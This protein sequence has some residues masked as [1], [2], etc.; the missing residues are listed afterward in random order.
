MK[1]IGYNIDYKILDAK[2][3][4]FHNQE[5]SNY[6]RMENELN[7]KYPNFETIKND[8]TINQ[9]FADLPK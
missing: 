9:L 8:I 6:N 1:E 7:F 4:V 2:D 3:L 5:K